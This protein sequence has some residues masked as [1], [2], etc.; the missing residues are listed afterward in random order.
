M[1]LYPAFSRKEHRKYHATVAAAI[2]S[3]FTDRERSDSLDLISRTARVAAK[4]SG[5]GE[6]GVFKK[7]NPVFP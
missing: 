5:N 3:F 6:A 7:R 2:F 4:S 1:V